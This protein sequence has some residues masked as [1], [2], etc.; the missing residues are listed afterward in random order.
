MRM[1]REK[2]TCQIMPPSPQLLLAAR[3][4]G[5]PVPPAPGQ[6]WA[7]C[8]GQRRQGTHSPP[9]SFSTC[10]GH[11]RVGE[12]KQ[13]IPVPLRAAA[14]PHVAAWG[15]AV[16]DTLWMF[17]PAP[18]V[19][20]T[21]LITHCCPPPQI[22]LVEPPQTRMCPSTI[23]DGS[24]TPRL[25]PTAPGHSTDPRGRPHTFALGDSLCLH[26]TLLQ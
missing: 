1:C 21:S 7:G 10:M 8:W 9:T 26:S 15:V 12:Q 3:N 11:A 2:P 4:G 20:S 24:A 5:G 25:D 22:Q 13:H 6:A 16:W 14:A 17:P 19:V 18:T 23:P